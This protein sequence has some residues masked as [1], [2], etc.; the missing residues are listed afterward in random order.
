M[1]FIVEFKSKNKETEEWHYY[2]SSKPLTTQE[3]LKTARK[4][5]SVETMHWLLDVHFREDFCRVE[6]KT[7]QQ[8]LNIGRKVA[9]NL[10]KRYKEKNAP[11]AS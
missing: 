3:L 1:L 2:I 6:D 8:A 10:V 9:L 7:L 4:E 5:W 11:K